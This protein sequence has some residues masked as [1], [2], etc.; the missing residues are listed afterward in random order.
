MLVDSATSE[1]ALDAF[2][3]ERAIERLGKESGGAPGLGFL[4][5]DPAGE[6]VYSGDVG[7]PRCLLCGR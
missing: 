7:P 4:I 5:F 3:Q 1:G 6:R 2:D